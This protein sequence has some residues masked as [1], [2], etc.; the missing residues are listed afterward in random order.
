[1]FRYLLVRLHRR[2]Y[3]AI[4]I[5]LQHSAKNLAQKPLT[6]GGEGNLAPLS[7]AGEGLGERSETV[8]TAPNKVETL[9][10]SGYPLPAAGCG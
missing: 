6:L 2:S 4:Y 5:T 1:M 9:V 8:N 3:A 10:A 7:R